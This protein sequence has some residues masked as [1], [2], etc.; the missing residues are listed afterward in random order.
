MTDPIAEV[1]ELVIELK[2]QLGAY[3]A[4]QSARLDEHERRISG[5]D[6]AI[7]DL[8]LADASHVTREELADRWSTTPPPAT[9]ASSS[10]VIPWVIAGLALIAP[11]LSALVTLVDK[12]AH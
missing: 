2:G 6:T 4:G 3:A 5:H 8:R 7:E 12:I 9:P 10:S 11:A 1:R